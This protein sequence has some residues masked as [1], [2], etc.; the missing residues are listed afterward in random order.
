[1]WDYFLFCGSLNNFESFFVCDFR[2]FATNELE[3]TIPSELGALA[4]LSN[5]S[6]PFHV[7]A[8]SSN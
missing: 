1:M 3:G 6:E 4:Q 5:M 2:N 8:N 7:N